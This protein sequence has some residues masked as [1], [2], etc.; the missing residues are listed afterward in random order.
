[1]IAAIQA[2]ALEDDK[3]YD[4]C[5][6][7]RGKISRFVQTSGVSLSKFATVVDANPQTVNK[8]LAK[9]GYNLGAS[10]KVYY[11]GYLFF[12]KYRLLCNEAK[13]AKRLK[14]EKEHPGGFR[15]EEPPKY[16]WTFA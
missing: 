12:E 14:N 9:K 3:V 15:L 8:F 16:V 7:I 5:D 13:T 2:V 10:S 11:N 4:D 6:E 1:M